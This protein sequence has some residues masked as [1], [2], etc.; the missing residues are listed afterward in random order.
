MAAL[1]V[2]RFCS[3][4]IRKWDYKRFPGLWKSETSS[5]E[6]RRPGPAA[7]SVSLLLLRVRRDKT[8]RENKKGIGRRAGGGGKLLKIFTTRSRVDGGGGIAA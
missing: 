5:R 4:R 8:S 7:G 6:G 2:P 1:R 3:I